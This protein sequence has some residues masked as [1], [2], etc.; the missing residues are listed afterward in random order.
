M[1]ILVVG[2]A[3]ADLSA[4]TPFY[5]GAGGEVTL[6]GLSWGSGG[7]GVN[8]ATGLAHLGLPARLLARVGTDMAAQQALRA[9]HRAGVDLGLLQHDTNRPT[10]LVF[11]AVLPSGERTFF[12]FRGANSACD[13]R[14]DD[15][16]VAGL[17]LVHLSA[18]ALLEGQQCETALTLARQAVRLGVPLT[19]DLA[20]PPLRHCPERL[21]ELLPCLTALFLNEDELALLLPNEQLE[22]GLA[23]I[24]EQW[25]VPL[26]ALK[27]GPQGCGVSAWGQWEALPALEV[28]ACDSTGCGDAFVAGF[29]YAHS[30]GAEPLVCAALG[31]LL[32][33]L[34]ATNFGTADALP[35]RAKVLEL[36]RHLPQPCYAACAGLLVRHYQ[37]ELA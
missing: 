22:A 13:A 4:A 7:A 1:A 24:H 9:A 8:T 28:P 34:T 27:R 15:T 19:L 5:P 6:A 29:L 3:N 30:R 37:G 14:L 25:R 10:G 33:G 20:P 23:R 31:N 35:S 18:Y 36:A 32:G 2:D 12:S 17:T 26:V 21:A 16:A 11:A